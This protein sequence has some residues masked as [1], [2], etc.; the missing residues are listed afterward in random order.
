MICIKCSEE[1]KDNSK[2][3]SSCGQ[4]IL[5]YSDLN[6]KKTEAMVKC[7]NC[8]YIGPGKPARGKASKILAWVIVPFAPLITVIYFLATHKYRCPKCLS[9]FLGVKNEKG[10]FV[11]QK[12]GV[13]RPL[14][15]VLLIFAGIAVVG[16]LS[17]VVLVS[18]N[19]A[20]SKARDA[21]RISDLFQISLALE[22]YATS[23]STELP[24]SLDSLAPTYMTAVPVDPMSGSYLYKK[25]SPTSYHL[26]TSLENSGNPSLNGDEDIVSMCPEDIING[27]D[28]NKCSPSDSGSYCYDI[29]FNS[30][31]K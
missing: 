4:E 31:L 5:E 18:L 9:T 19:S 17:S 24:V 8:E 25:C 7:G 3:C 12:G 11:G 16:I 14:V 1:I 2:F 21:R 28:S 23:K 29:G 22:N 30:N 27:I 13:A 20:R 15:I 26:A 6:T 10:I